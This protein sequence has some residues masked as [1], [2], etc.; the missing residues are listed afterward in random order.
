MRAEIWVKLLAEAEQAIDELLELS[1]S[2]PKLDPDREC[3]AGTAQ[4]EERISR[5][6]G[7]EVQ[8]ERRPMPGFLLT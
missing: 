8:D 6:D 2:A 4:T 5:S 1:G 3:D 7:V